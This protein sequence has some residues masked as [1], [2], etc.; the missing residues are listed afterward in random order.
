VRHFETIEELRTALA[1]FAAQYNASWLRQR[2]GYKT[3]D[4]IRAEQKVL[5]A[6]AATAIMMAA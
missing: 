1:E 6:D 2:N 4:Q 3:P 5:E